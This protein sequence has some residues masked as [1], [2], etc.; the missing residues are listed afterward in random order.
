MTECKCILY[1]SFLLF[2]HFPVHLSLFP[3]PISTPY[4]SSSLPFNPFQSLL[5]VYHPKTFLSFLNSFLLP[6]SLIFH[7]SSS[8]SQAA[9]H[10]PPT[11]PVAAQMDVDRPNCALLSWAPASTSSQATTRSIYVLERQEVGSQEWQK[12]VTT[13]V[14]TSVEIMGDSVP[15]EG[16]FRFRVCCVNKYGRSGHVEFPKF[17]HLGECLFVSLH[18]HV[19]I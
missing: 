7:S 1:R 5:L 9:K 8:T 14:D 13:D 16:D 6:L 17:V 3:F 19:V 11:C 2:F 10:S 12:C 4:P 18:L 15:Y